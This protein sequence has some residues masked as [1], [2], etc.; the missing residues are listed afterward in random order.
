MV[1]GFFSW[2]GEVI[3]WISEHEWILNMIHELQYTA[4]GQT[5]VV[6]TICSVIITWVVI[7]ISFKRKESTKFLNPL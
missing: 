6:N 7:E 2:K 5:I 4:R 3:S 1:W